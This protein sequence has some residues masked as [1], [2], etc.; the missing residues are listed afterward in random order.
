M[1]SLNETLTGGVYGAYG[2]GTSPFAMRG[3][4]GAFSLI[5]VAIFLIISLILYCVT[6]PHVVFY[7]EVGAEKNES[8]KPSAAAIMAHGFLNLFINGVMVLLFFWYPSYRGQMWNQMRNAGFTGA[9]Q[10]LG[11]GLIN[12][13]N[14]VYRG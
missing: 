11:Q 7:G 4:T 2:M 9:R 12:A 5:S 8:C 3:P 10:Y 14:S 13:G 1:S 6:L